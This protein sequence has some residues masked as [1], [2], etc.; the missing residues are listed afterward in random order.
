MENCI[1]PRSFTL[2]SSLACFKNILLSPKR[3][4]S[5]VEELIRITIK[6]YY[7]SIYSNG[8]E[9]NCAFNYIK[10]TLGN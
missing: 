3:N 7:I 4:Y 1:P 6:Q 10:G 9:W 8:N 2:H 5:F